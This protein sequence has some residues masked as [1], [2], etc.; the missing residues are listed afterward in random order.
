MWPSL[1]GHFV[2]DT[3]LFNS[4]VTSRTP[5]NLL[6]PP[7]YGDL[8]NKIHVVK[9]A[10]TTCYPTDTG[11]QKKLNILFRDI[12]QFG[13]ALRSGRRG[14][15]F[16]SCYPDKKYHIT[17]RWCDTFLFRKDLNLKKARTFQKT[18]R[19]TVFSVSGAK[20][21]TVPKARSTSRTDCEAIC[22]PVIPIKKDCYS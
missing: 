12:A 9:Q 16:K 3:V 8:K 1:V 4:S 18:V 17:A 7:L 22:D 5:T 11:I 21:G 19:V 6:T 14:R 13:S 10:L 15:R 20:S 2:R